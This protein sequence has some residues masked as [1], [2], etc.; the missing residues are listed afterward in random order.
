[1]ALEMFN[2]LQFLWHFC[3]SAGLYTSLPAVAAVLVRA[4]VGAEVSSPTQDL[5]RIS[6]ISHVLMNLTQSDVID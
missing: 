1:M 2:T 6:S 3:I 4:I 5:V